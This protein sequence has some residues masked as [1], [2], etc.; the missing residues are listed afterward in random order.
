MAEICGEL[1][2]LLTVLALAPAAAQT[3]AQTPAQTQ[4][5]TPATV[6]VRVSDCAAYVAHQAADDV[7]YRPERDAAQGVLPADIAPA[8][9]FN[10][11]ARS[12][13]F[14]IWADVLDRG[15]DG[16]PARRAYAADG[17]I[18]VIEVRDGV[19]YLDDRPLSNHEAE[20]LRALCLSG[21]DGGPQKDR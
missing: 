19:P 11:R 2:A 17:L 4:A 6:V 16:H 10:D 9:D 18:A 21:A 13:D 7:A 8:P 3:L 1:T 5:Q 20:R 15:S 14:A 12:F